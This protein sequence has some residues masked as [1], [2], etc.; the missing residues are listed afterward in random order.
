MRLLIRG[1]FAWLKM[2]IDLRMA[3]VNDSGS[4]R[5]YQSSMFPVDFPRSFGSLAKG[6]VALLFLVVVALLGRPGRLA[7]QDQPTLARQQMAS[8]RNRR[9]QTE[10]HKLILGPT[11]KDVKY[12]VIAREG[13]TARNTVE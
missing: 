1:G 3:K 7:A 8:G 2:T 12:Q 6:L 10:G 5:A 9:R 11:G 13:Y 4:K